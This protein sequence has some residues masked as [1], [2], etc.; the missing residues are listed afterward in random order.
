MTLPRDLVERL[1]QTIKEDR[2]NLEQLKSGALKLRQRLHGKDWE[3]I[4]AEA[5]IQRER[6]IATYQEII[7]RQERPG[8]PAAAKA[9][10]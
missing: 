3:D 6:T 9:R 2:A 7:G 8:Q 5:I 1:E 4:T 10:K